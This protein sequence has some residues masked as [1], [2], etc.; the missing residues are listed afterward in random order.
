MGGLKYRL[1]LNLDRTDAIRDVVP[2][3]LTVA[4]VLPVVSSEVLV[5][6]VPA[7]RVALVL[8]GL[9]IADQ[10][11]HRV[12]VVPLALQEPDRYR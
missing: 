9:Q 6:P 10:A 2:V 4:L 7:I 3:P 5:L 8:P 11:D 1:H 12:M